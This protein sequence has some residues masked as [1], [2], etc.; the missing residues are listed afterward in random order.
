MFN[1]WKSVSVTNPEHP[2]AGQAGT[3]FA[4]NAE[5]HPDEVTVKFDAD[6]TLEAVKNADLKGL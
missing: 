2:R 6:G 3:V 4:V 1:V 5:T